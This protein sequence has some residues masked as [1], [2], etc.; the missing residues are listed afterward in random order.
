MYAYHDRI[1]IKAIQRGPISL[2]LVSI[3]E[4]MVE[5]RNK[6]SWDQQTKAVTVNPNWIVFIVYELVM[7]R[8]T[9]LLTKCLAPGSREISGVLTRGQF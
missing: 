3:V 7:P 5:F 8:Y 4:N 2:Q 1:W 6:Y 9:G